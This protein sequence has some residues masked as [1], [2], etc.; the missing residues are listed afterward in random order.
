MKPISSGSGADIGGCE[1]V[2]QLQ[3]HHRA[4]VGVGEI[5]DELAEDEE[6]ED[7]AAQAG[8][9]LLDRLDDVGQ[10]SSACRRR[11]RR[12]APVTRNITMISAIRPFMN[13]ELPISSPVVGIAQRR[14][15]RQRQ[16]AEDHERPPA[17]RSTAHLKPRASSAESSAPCSAGFSPSAM[18]YASRGSIDPVGDERDEDRQ[19]HDRGDGEPEVRGQADRSCWDRPGGSRRW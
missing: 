12:P 13:G 14:A 7:R 3:G 5:G 15:R 18:S 4:H 9:R 19:E 16:Q 8:D 1:H 2:G 11:C 6:Q 10:R 17:G